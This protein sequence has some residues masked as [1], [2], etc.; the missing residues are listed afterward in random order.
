MVVCSSNS[1]SSVCNLELDGETLKC[2]THS[3][4]ATN[5]VGRWYDVTE[6]Y[7]E[8]GDKTICYSTMNF[9]ERDQTYN[10]NSGYREPAVVTNKY[11]GNGRD[12]DSS[13]LEE[14]GMPSGS[15]AEQFLTQLKSDFAAMATSVEKNGG[16]YISRY[17]IGEGG[18]S[19]KSQ[20]VL[21]AASSDGGT[22]ETAYLGVKNWYGLYR[23]IRNVNENK[24]MIWGC[25]YDQV[26]RFLK[27]GGEEVEIGHSDIDLTTDHAL[28]GQN[29]LDCM[30]N[31][32]DLEGNHN[33]WTTQAFSDTSRAIRGNSYSDVIDDYFFPASNRY[34]GS[35][36][37]SN[38]ILSSRST[39]YIGLE[40]E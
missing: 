35:P 16:F 17:E 36:G 20:E 18:S 21:T 25:Q 13:N 29:E 11:L 6:T 22:G 5:L 2:T 38:E 37:D 28:S 40:E 27:D 9:K 3:A 32:Y 7:I 31:I 14:A 23:T 30:K 33:E 15:T 4:T 8:E 10:D 34:A 39:L 26:I 12:G 19:K 24:Q 1:G